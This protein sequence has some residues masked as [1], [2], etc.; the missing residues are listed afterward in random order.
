MGKDASIQVALKKDRSE[1]GPKD[2]HEKV[3]K[4]KAPSSK[5]KASASSTKK[6]VEK[7]KREDS[8]DEGDEDEKED[9]QE[10]VFDELSQSKKKTAPPKGDT[11]TPNQKLLGQVLAS[12][13]QFVVGRIQ[14]NPADVKSPPEKFAARELYPEHLKNLFLHFLTGGVFVAQKDF[15]LFMEEV[16][17]FVS[18]FFYI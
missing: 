12:M 18:L 2:K 3:V 7:R 17:N 15:I 8:S 14:V 9:E 11:Q 16:W 13:A 6:K 5:D 10:D 4:S 1:S